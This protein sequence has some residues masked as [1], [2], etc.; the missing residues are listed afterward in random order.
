MCLS[1]RKR[2]V[3]CRKEIFKVIGWRG[4][5]EARSQGLMAPREAWLYPEGQE[6]PCLILN[7]DR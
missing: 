7:S 4:S 6:S 3:R 2:V 5:Q 1:R